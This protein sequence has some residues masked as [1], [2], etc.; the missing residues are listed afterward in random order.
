MN[1]AKKNVSFIAKSLHSCFLAAQTCL[2][3][4]LHNHNSIYTWRCLVI[5]AR[6]S[7]PRGTPML[8]GSAVKHGAGCHTLTIQGSFDSRLG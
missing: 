5:F 8:D 4:Q 2:L 3:L 7:H 1:N 6:N